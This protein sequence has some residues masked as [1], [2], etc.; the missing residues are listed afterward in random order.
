MPHKLPIFQHVLVVLLWQHSTDSPERIPL[1]G[2]GIERTPCL[3]SYSGT[4]GRQSVKPF[5]QSSVLGPTPSPSVPSPLWF[6][7]TLACGRAGGGVPIP[8]RGHTLWYLNIYMYFVRRD[9]VQRILDIVEDLK[10]ERVAAA[11]ASSHDRGPP[12]TL[13]RYHVTS[14]M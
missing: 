11:A 2:T 1:I 7:G 5:L 9:H 14:V 3:L 4:Q 8:T 10:E 12:S 6:R 13:D